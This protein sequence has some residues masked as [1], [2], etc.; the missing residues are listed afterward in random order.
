MFAMLLF[1]V[2]SSLIFGISLSAERDSWIV[3]LFAGS[4][5]LLLFHMYVYIWRNNGFKNLASLLYSNLGKHLGFVIS[6][7]YICYFAYLASRV[8]TDFTFF[9]NS[10]LLYAMHPFFIKFSIFLVIA[11]T[12]FNGLEAFIRSA[13]ILGTITLLFLI[14]LPILIIVGGNFNWEYVDPIL[15]FNLEK[16][17]GSIPTMIV[18]PFG[19]IIAFLMIFPF[20]NRND[21]LGVSKK[22]SI[23]IIF[24]TI[25][26]SLFSFLIIGVL[27]PELAKNYTYPMITTIERVTVFD[28]L[29]RL[30][31]LAIFIFI[32]AGYFKISVFTFAS[33]NLAKE[34][35][36]RLNPKFLTL[37]ILGI[38]YVLSFSFS[39]NLSQHLEV[40]LEVIPTL[41]H[42]P[43]A[44]LLPTLIF[45]ITLIK[46]KRMKT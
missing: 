22:G 15:S 7:V 38:I 42:L 44:V 8:L 43:L 16:I 10:K 25:C 34:N 35:I 4:M 3:S 33:I 6:L 23:I 5:G 1:L 30:D 29:E 46:K 28:F 17:I 45:I 32:T 37:S 11:Y 26:L 2:G 27:H 12:Y 36:S 18:F 24:F 14:L 40:G 39:K 20:L 21:R 9:I 31:I 19:E 41:V 13:V